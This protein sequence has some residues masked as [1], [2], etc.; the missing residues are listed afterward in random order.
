MIT[1]EDIR[2]S[3]EINTYIH[4]ADESLEALGY[5]EHSLPHVGK[6]AATAGYILETMGYDAHQVELVKIAAYLHDIG[7]LVNR[8]DHSQSGAIMAF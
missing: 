6:T 1:F 8:F 7:N 2:K 4:K 5:T 3:E